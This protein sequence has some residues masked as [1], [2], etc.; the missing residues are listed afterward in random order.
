VR[1]ALVGFGDGR[2]EEVFGVF[3]APGLDGH[4]H[5][6]DGLREQRDGE[7]LADLERE[8]L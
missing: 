5:V 2:V 6:A 4:G 7:V 3:V 8:R 1:V